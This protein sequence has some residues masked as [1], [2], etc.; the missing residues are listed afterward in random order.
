MPHLKEI[1]WHWNKLLPLIRVRVTNILVV[2][3][4]GNFTENLKLKKNIYIHI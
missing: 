1:N 2:Q 3:D 4:V